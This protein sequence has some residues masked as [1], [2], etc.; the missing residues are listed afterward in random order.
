LREGASLPQ[1]DKSRT[2]GLGGGSPWGDFDGDDEFRQNDLPE[3]AD[4]LTG[5]DGA[6]SDGCD[7][8]DV[9]GDGDANLADFAKLQ[10][11]YCGP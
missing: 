7:C 11:C 3:V 6:L 4:C 9:T 5:P 10:T 1:T 2:S 8:L